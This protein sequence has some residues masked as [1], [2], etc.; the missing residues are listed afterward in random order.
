[1][2]EVLNEFEVH[3][4]N[5]FTPNRDG[6]NDYFLPIFSDYG[7]ELSFY[8]LEIFDRWDHLIYRSTDLKKGWD[9]KAK[10][11]LCQEGS[12]VY[13]LRFSDKEKNS[14]EKIGH[15]LLLGSD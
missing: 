1:L 13:R 4:P 5:T 11:E 10:N 15:V 12:Y 2:I 8:T 6:L 3:I 7:V 9:G 14:H